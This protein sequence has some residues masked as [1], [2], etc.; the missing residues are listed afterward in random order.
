MAKDRVTQEEINELFDKSELKVW[1]PFDNVTVC[2]W[3]FENGFTITEASGCINSANYDRNIGIK[4]CRK[5]AE[6]KLWMLEGYLARIGR[7]E[8]GL[9]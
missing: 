4:I 8:E 3:R 6:D 9:N 7:Y 2:T 1:E 5:H